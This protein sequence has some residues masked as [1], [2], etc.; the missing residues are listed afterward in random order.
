MPKMPIDRNFVKYFPAIVNQ[1][2]GNFNAG[3]NLYFER[4]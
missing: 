4:Y 3:K 2:S 1:N